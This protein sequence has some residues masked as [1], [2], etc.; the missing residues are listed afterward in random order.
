MGTNSAGQA[1]QAAQ[2]QE[3]ERQSRIYQTTQR[4]NQAY[5]APARQGQYDDFLKAVRQ[6]YMGDANRQKTVA[7][8]NLKFSLARSGL[9][10]GSAAVDANRTSGEEYNRGILQAEDRAQSALGD[11]KSQ[12]ETSRLQL[13]QL[14]QSGLDT[15]TAAN[16]AAQQMATGAQTALAGSTAKGL[17][18]IFGSTASTYKQQQEAAARRQGQLAPVGGLYGNATWGK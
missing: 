5:D 17:G 4:I 6:N 13:T 1:Q 15:T 18:D 11:L 2:Q 7:D 12:D 14:A 9:T 16:R 10:G 8:R 3:T